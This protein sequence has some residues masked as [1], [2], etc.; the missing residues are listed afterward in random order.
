M[1][2]MVSKIALLPPTAALAGD[3]VFDYGAPDAT[4]PELVVHLTR[5][6]GQKKGHITIGDADVCPGPGTLA[7]LDTGE[8]D[9][10]HYY[11][12]PDQGAN[13]YSSSGS[14]SGY[15]RGTCAQISA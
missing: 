6:V 13:D 4:H 14:M 12:H 7:F 11:V 15:G 3:P 9:A 2:V 8:G 5:Y 10:L 1:K